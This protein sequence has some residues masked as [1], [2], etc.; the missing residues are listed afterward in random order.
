MFFRFDSFPP[1]AT[2][3]LP[4]EVSIVVPSGLDTIILVIQL[5]PASLFAHERTVTKPSDDYSFDGTEQLLIVWSLERENMST[6]KINTVAAVT[7][8]VAL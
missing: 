2:K 8:G 6:P 4:L 5:L 3:R 1:A 7:V